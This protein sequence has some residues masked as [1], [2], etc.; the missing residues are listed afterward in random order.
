MLGAAAADGIVFGGSGYR[1]PAAQ[2]ALRRAHCGTSTYA[3]YEMPP[4][5]CTPPTAIPGTSMHERGLAVDFTVN[6]SAI[7]SRDSTG[8]RWL[9]S[10]A[11]RYGFYNLPSEPWHWSV[12]GS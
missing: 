4:S 9:A 12:N 1:D 8:F 2:I 3:I 11:A 10:N 6:G 5:Q 7:T